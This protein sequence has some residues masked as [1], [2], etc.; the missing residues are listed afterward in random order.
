MQNPFGNTPENSPRRA[1][2]PRAASP[3]EL[4]A[5]ECPEGGFDVFAFEPPGVLPSDFEAHRVDASHV[6]LLRVDTEEETE[7]VGP[8]LARKLGADYER[9]VGFREPEPG[10][11][12]R[13]MAL[14]QR[15]HKHGATGY[16]LRQGSDGCYELLLRRKDVPLLGR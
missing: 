14:L 15:L 10:K 5:Y 11:K 12:G 4:V 7:R 6:F 13:A 1:V 8:A 16:L 3:I 9:V 2:H